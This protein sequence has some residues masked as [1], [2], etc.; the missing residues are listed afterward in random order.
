MLRAKSLL[1]VL[2]VFTA[3]IAAS[4]ATPAASPGNASA[5]IERRVDS[6]LS[7][8]TLEEKIDYVGGVRGFYVREMP[9]L[10][11]PALKMSDGPLGVRNY[12]PATTFPAGIS[13]AAS[14]DP[15][16][17]YRMGS[18]IG[19]DARARGVHFMLGPGVNIYKA[20][21][22]GRNFEYFGEDPFLASRMAVGYIEGMQEQGVSA[23]IKHYMGNNSEFLLHD[24]NSQIDERTMREIYLPT[25]EAGVKEA[26]VG[27]IMDSYNLINGSH[28][29]ENDYLNNQVA[30][31]DWGFDG[32]IMSDWVATYDGV[33]AAKGGLDI[34]M[35]SGRFMNRKNLLP[36]VQKGEVPVAVIDDKVRRILRTAIRFGWLDRD[37]LDSSIPAYNLQGREAALQAVREGMVLLKNDGRLLPLDKNGVKTVLVVGPDAYPLDPVGGGSARVLPFSGVSFMEGISDYLGTGATVQYLRGLPSLSEIAKATNFVTETKG[38]QAG[39]TVES[40]PG[41]DFSGAPTTTRIERHVDVSDVPLDLSLIDEDAITAIL[42]RKA[43]LSR[44]TGYYFP[45]QSGTYDIFVQGL[46]EG[47]AYRLYVDGKLVLDNWHTFTALLGQTS[48]PLAAAPHKIVLEDSKRYSFGGPVIRMGIALQGSL[49]DSSLKALAEKADAV[50]VVAGFDHENESEG[51]DRTFALPIGQESLIREATA[52]NKKTIVVMESGGAVDAAPWLDHTA[53]LIESWYPGQEAGRALAEVLFGDINP[54]GR[55]PVS[56]ERRLEDNPTYRTYYPLPNSNN[57]AYTEGIFVGYRGYEHG[58]Q[59]PLFPFG[60][61]LSYTTFKYSNLVVTP[62][63]ADGHFVVSFD[64]SD[65]GSRAGADVA[66]VYVSDTHAKV[67]RPLKELKGFARVDLQPGELKHVRVTLEPRSFTYFDVQAKQWHAD[68]GPYD[69]LVGSSSDKIELKGSANLPKALTLNR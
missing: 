17:A 41:E 54:S 48:L 13:L 38:G 22:N 65:T 8:M 59:K 28:A 68:A 4:Q 46:G 5:D 1:F 37:Q 58:G 18:T 14:W 52:A 55:L 3:S 39:L 36:A 9:R 24:S 53:A 33:A 30:K 67:P 26:H 62:V 29:T 63:G 16:L 19:R 51:S 43:Q 44:W 15:E 2:F 6:I 32:V 34:E 21:M 64:V 61:G 35:P 20:P 27:A 7:Q 31:K 23:T 25:F 60:F 12:G 66:Q 56:W 49:V 57:V 69:I 47:G 42:S 10:H 40:F 45:Q 11:V 50:V